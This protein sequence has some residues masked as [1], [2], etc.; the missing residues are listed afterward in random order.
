M[1]ASR[2]RARCPW[3]CCCP[4]Q[5]P[6]PAQGRPVLS[7]GSLSAPLAMSAPPPV[8]GWPRPLPVLLALDSACTHWAVGVHAL[9]ESRDPLTAVLSGRPW[10]GSQSARTQ[11]RTGW[12]DL[13]R[14][15]GLSGPPFQAGTRDLG[16]GRFV[17]NQ[18]TEF[19][20][21]EIMFVILA[22]GKTNNTKKSTY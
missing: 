16:A 21:C 17:Q 1:A 7:S 2:G 20:S 13:D 10:A 22:G 14:P 11:P 15:T 3:S 4:S 8:L 12:V 18:K 5:T 9:P 6:P 19:V